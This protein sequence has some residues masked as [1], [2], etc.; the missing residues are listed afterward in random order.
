MGN[1][2][3]GQPT[4]VQISFT[5]DSV[6]C[7]G[8][9]TGSLTANVSNGVF[10]YTYLWDANANNQNTATAS[11]LAAGTYTVTVTDFNGCTSVATGTV[12]QPA[13]GLTATIIRQQDPS[14]FGLSDGF[15]EVDAQ[16]ATPNYTYRWSNGQTTALATGLP[17]GP[18]SVT[19]TDANGC[20]TTVGSVLSQPTA[21]VLNPQ[22]RSNYNGAAIS[23]P[24]AADGAVDVTAAGGS[25]SFSYVWS[26]IGQNTAAINGLVQGTYCVTVTDINGCQA[27]TCITL[28]DPV[29]L[30]ATFTA[31]DVLC[32]G[33]Q[34]GQII[35]TATPGTGTLGVNGYEYAISGPGQTGNVF[36]NQ[37]TWNNLAAGSYTVIVRDGNDC[38]LILP[39]A[40]N[41][42]TQILIDSVQVTEPL[43]NGGADGQANAIASGG[44]PP[45]T[46]LWS[47]NQTT[48]PAINLAAGLYSVTVSDNNGCDRVQVFNIGEPTALSANITADSIDCF[49]GSSNA[50][51]TAIGGTPVGLT[52]YLYRWDNGATTQTVVGLPA[53]V[54]C[55]TITDDNACTLVECVT[56]TQPSAPLVLSLSSS[57]PNCNG[58]TTGAATATAAG[59]TAPYSFVWSDGQTTATALN[60]GAGTYTVTATDA[61]GCTTVGNIT[62]SNPAGVQASITTTGGVTC[63][64]DSTGTATVSV[65]VGVAPYTYL[66]SN[67]ETTATAVALGAGAASVTVT[68]AN[69]CTAVVGTTISSVSAVQI[70]N[71][72]TTPVNCRGGADGTASVSVAGGSPPYVYNWSGAVGQNSPAVTG[73]SAGLQYVT[74]TDANGCAAVDSFTITEPTQGLTGYLVS[75][76]ALCAGQN[77]GQLAAIVTG[78]TGSYSYN[79]SDGQTTAVADSLVAGTYTVTI[80]DSLGCTWS[81]SGS[82]SDPTP[83]QVTAQIDQP[84]TCANGDN[85]AVSIQS[86]S[87]GSQPYSYIWNDVNGSTTPNLTGLGAGTYIILV[88]DTNFCRAADTV[89]LTDGQP[90]NITAS[91][92]PISC[93]GQADGSIDLGSNTG[94]GTYLWSNGAVTSQITNLGAGTYTVTVTDVDLCS[95]SFSYTLTEPSALSLSVATLS[96]V[97]CNG[98]STGSLEVA[99]TGGTLPY[100]YNWSSGAGNALTGRLG[101]G[102]Y[103]VTVTDANGCSLT[104]SATLSEPAAL[105]VSGVSTATRCAG[106]AT[107]T[108]AAS[109]SGGTV[110]TGVLEFR[111]VEANG[112]A[113]QSGNLFSGL[114]AG[115]YTLQVRDEVGCSAETMLTV[116]DADP[117]FIVSMTADTTI[118]YGDSLQ[119]SARLNDTLGVQFSWTA[120][121]GSQSVV[122][123]SEY[124]FG[125]RPIERAQYQFSAVNPAG[126]E[127]DSIVTIDVLKIRRANAPTAFTPNGDGVNDFF[128]IQGGEKVQSVVV[129]RVYDR[130]GTLVFEGANMEANV[131]EQGWNGNFRGQPSTSGTYTWY[132]D[133]QFLDGEV[134][135]IKGNITLLR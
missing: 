94:I 119:V 30:A 4:A 74:I 22:I 27:D 115:I 113:W 77:S 54:H 133:V 65:S 121:T 35:V 101:A 117:F 95:A 72:T 29:P 61:N 122:T 49:G 50:T 21:I 107:G 79:W 104:E 69:G 43:C 120:L 110:L 37:N 106:D 116:Q 71:L 42:P 33:D 80:T 5:S 12:A 129:F 62:L 28:V 9:S 85:G 32:F 114:G 7:F 17:A 70:T 20:S 56:I 41:E 59:G 83:L 102:T 130:W 90:V 40:I 45:Y 53:G 10:P 76:N 44:T 108:V 36:S 131:P 16:G 39:I 26:P 93:N 6:D 89:T 15:M 63:A 11:N 60:L 31:R 13:T 97:T 125:I 48:N 96:T 38:E 124:N 112:G 23:C 18:H 24:G 19:I 134:T 81:Q 123:T 103:T 118:E 84:V 67:G 100:N 127:V 75:T 99:G 128:F 109:G 91:T 105:D 8:A 3:V 47:D 73:L 66:W 25:G 2:T 46:Y 92:T 14:C 82:V 88:T 52:G 55:V 111:L 86:V 126:C 68:D 58:D 78:G 51:V 135:Q 57:D 132:A 34:N 1:T 98:D 87:G 64:G